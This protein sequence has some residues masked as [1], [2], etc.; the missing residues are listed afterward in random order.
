MELDE[1]QDI[2]KS[3]STSGSALLVHGPLSEEETRRAA[4]ELR[5]REA[6]ERHN[7][8]DKAEAA[9]KDRQLA[10]TDLSL[11]LARSNRN[12][13]IALAIF[14]ACGRAAAIFQGCVGSKAARAAQDAVGVAS[15]SLCEN[16][17]SNTRQ[18]F[19]RSG[20]SA[21]QHRELEIR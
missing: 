7:E 11:K 18:Y 14:T 15:K 21:G 1:P 8:A 20:V 4:D 19:P 9:Y 13:T 10:Q 3:H 12:L 16:Q 5:I 2:Q 6:I 17:R